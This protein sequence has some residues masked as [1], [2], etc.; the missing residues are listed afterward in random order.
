MQDLKNYLPAMSALTS[1][2]SASRYLSF[3]AAAKELGV[4]ASAISQQISLLENFWGLTLFDRIDPRRIALTSEG[5]TISSEL[6]IQLNKLANHFEN[7]ITDE[8]DAISICCEDELYAYWLAPKLAEYMAVTDDKTNF[9]IS[10]LSCADSDFPQDFDFFFLLA[11]QNT[12]RLIL[13]H[14]FRQ[15][16]FCLYALIG[17]LRIC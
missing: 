8:D 14:S 3:T 2:E 17:T 11:R 9:R 5:I 7:L 1:F 16:Q 6:T 15:K 13:L 10:L 4:T 12:I